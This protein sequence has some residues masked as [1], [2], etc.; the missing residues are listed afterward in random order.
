[1]IWQDQDNFL[2]ILKNEQRFGIF[3]DMGVGKTALMLAL[4]DYKFFQQIR[5]VLII[6]PKKVSLSTWQMEIDKWKNFNYMKPIV[7]LV[8]GDDRKRRSILKGTNDFCIHIISSALTSWLVGERTRKGKRIFLEPNID[9]PKYDLIVVDECSQFK[10]PTSQR[11]KALKTLSYGKELFLLSGTAI[12][13]IERDKKTGQYLKADELYY[14]FF[15]LGIYLQSLTQFRTDFCYTVKWDEY[16]YKMTPEIYDMLMSKLNQHSI[17]K[18]LVLDVPMQQRRVYCGIDSA[19][20]RQLKDD[21]YIETDGFAK[22]TAANK[23]IMINKTLQLSNG[24]VYDTEQ[25]AVR[26]NTYKFEK[27]VQLLAHIKDNVIIFYNFKE[28]REFLLA[29]LKGA[30]LYDGDNVKGEWNE[31]KIRYLILSPFSEKYGLNLQDGGHTVIWFGLVWS[32]ESYEQANARIYR[33]GQTKAVDVYYILAQDGF[34]DYVYNKLVAKT[35]VID[36][37]INYIER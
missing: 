30:R 23:A 11:F 29:N 31:G 20:L 4:A 24:F 10:D 9:T 16:N 1:M 8:D 32:A 3:L 34:D 6:T 25:K 26:Y 13:N 22:I 36:E 21:Y 2:E 33:R 28:D 15:L 12:S 27:L 19:R 14:L 35:S 18:K 37:F 17:R 5:K 7:S